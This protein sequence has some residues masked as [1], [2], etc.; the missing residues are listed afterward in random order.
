M[1][2]GCE[3]KAQPAETRAVATRPRLNAR[4]VCATTVPAVV[5]A[6]AKA[7][8]AIAECALVHAQALPNAI[9]GEPREQRALAL[10]EAA[11]EV[12]EVDSH[13]PQASSAA[14]R[15]SSFAA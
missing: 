5:V 1:C 13:R 10:A 12:V 9:V 8:V 6:L 7:N 2:A 15:V 11:R 4:D 3:T 14:R